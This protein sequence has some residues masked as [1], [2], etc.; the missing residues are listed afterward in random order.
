V[1]DWANSMKPTMN[2]DKNFANWVLFELQHCQRCLAEAR[3]RT[4]ACIQR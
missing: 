4:A 2:A 1:A 3:P